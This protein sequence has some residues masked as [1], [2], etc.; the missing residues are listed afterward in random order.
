M[1]SLLNRTCSG[2]EDP[3]VCGRT[4]CHTLEGEREAV[5]V[6]ECSRDFRL[7]LL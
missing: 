4:T 6:I 1:E 3:Y 7:K 5:W 2:S